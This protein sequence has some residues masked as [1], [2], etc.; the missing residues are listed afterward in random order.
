MSTF[1]STKRKKN[2]ANPFGSLVDPSAHKQT[3]RLPAEFRVE[4]YYTG[5]V[6][7]IGVYIIS[8]FLGV[9]VEDFS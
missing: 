5:Y 8:Q 3:G 6:I 2:F 7:I 9:T 1:K 4:I